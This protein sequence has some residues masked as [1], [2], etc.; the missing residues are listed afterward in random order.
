MVQG[1]VCIQCEK[2]DT[3]N[4]VGIVVYVLYIVKILEQK[5]KN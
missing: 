2:R 4:V 5:K 3:W 1:M